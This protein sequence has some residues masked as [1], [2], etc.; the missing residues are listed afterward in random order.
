MLNLC[1]TCR[2]LTII[3]QSTGGQTLVSVIYSK[4]RKIFAIY[5]ST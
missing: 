4:D 3:L 1:G 2:S 5:H